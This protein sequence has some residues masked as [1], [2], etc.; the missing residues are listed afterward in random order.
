MIKQLLTFS[1]DQMVSPQLVNLNSVLAEVGR[2][3]PRLIGENVELVI[4]ND[5]PLRLV[6]VTLDR[7]FRVGD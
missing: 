1:R 4:A 3:L 2:M 7:C 6:K 5:K